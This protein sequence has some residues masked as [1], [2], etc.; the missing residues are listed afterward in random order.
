[1]AG[2]TVNDDNN[3]AAC[4][5]EAMAEF[6]HEIT[7]DDVKD[8]MGYPKPDAITVLLGKH[9]IADSELVDKIHEVFVNK[10][11]N[12]YSTHPQIKEKSGASETFR[13]LKA[14]GVGVG[15]DTGFSRNITNAIIDR[16]GWMEH[17]LIDVSVS[18]DEVA[19]G[20]PHPD[21]IYKA[22]DLLNISSASEVV[23]VGD[24]IS[25]LQEGHSAGCKYVIGITTGTNTREELAA[26]YNT[27]LIDH[28]SSVADIVLADSEA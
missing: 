26:A 9:G 24:T 12:F 15:L 3:V 10:M 25:D 13:R 27:H 2:T 19:H 1:M 4:V 6:G 16:M 8:V 11:I 28:I 23:K 7:I 21:M 17:N 18:S 20:R 5:K 22:M 14:S